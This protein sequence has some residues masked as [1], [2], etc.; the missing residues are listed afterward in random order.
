MLRTTQN[1]VSKNMRMI[2]EWDYEKN[3]SFGFDP[4]KIGQNSHFKVWC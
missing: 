1:T 2:E 4:S 3:D